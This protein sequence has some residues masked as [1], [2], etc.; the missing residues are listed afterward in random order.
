MQVLLD[1]GSTVT[2][3][4]P[5]VLSE[6]VGCRSTVKVT[7]VQGDTQEVATAHV[8]IGNERGEWKLT[9]G[10]GP[11]LLIALLLGG[12]WPGFPKDLPAARRKRRR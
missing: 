3:V 12:N 5:S 9:V 7:C 10:V 11:D 8:Q 1:S 6:A 4:Q 2:L